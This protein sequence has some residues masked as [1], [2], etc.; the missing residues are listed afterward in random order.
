MELPF[1]RR[2]GRRDPA[3]AEENFR[4]AADINPQYTPLYFNLAKALVKSGRDDDARL[5]Y[6]IAL[7]ID[8]GCREALI[9]LGELELQ[10]GHL[11]QSRQHLLAA[12]DLQ[13]ADHD[14]HTLLARL[15]HRLDEPEL[16]EI[17]LNLTRAYPKAALPN[18]KIRASV[19]LQEA[20][21]INAL[22]QQGNALFNVG[23]FAEAESVYR[24]LVNLRNDS[25]GFHM[26][27]GKTLAEQG[28]LPEAIKELESAM[29]LDD[30]NANVVSTC[31][32]LLARA[33]QLE[34][35]REMLKKAVELDPNS[36]EAHFYSGMTLEQQ[37]ELD[38]AVEAFRRTVE[39]NP[40]NAS[41]HLYLANLLAKQGD[42]DQAMDHWRLA[43]TYQPGMIQAVAPLVQAYNKKGLYAK[44]DELLRR[45]FK[46]S[47]AN[48][49]ILT[50]LASHLAE[51]PDPQFRNRAEA[52]RV[53]EQL[54][55]IRGIDKVRSLV[56][57]ANV[58]A[59]AGQYQ[60][61]IGTLQLAQ[62]A[63]ASGRNDPAI[64]QLILSKQQEYLD[65]NTD[66]KSLQQ[67][68]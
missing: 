64:A 5:E 52:I 8:P 36:D 18:D 7:R 20:T 32:L 10:N 28:K 48:P 53:A 11:E 67:D 15:Y 22:V 4:R 19:Y 54:G 24:Q 14:V 33:G 40:A 12:A 65:R 42:L 23:R 34:R 1:R 49:V 3:N 2:V 17:E 29:A 31:G 41:G 57:L 39:L 62:Q 51:C 47:P 43:L 30:Q 60:R 21:G 46:R 58:L 25:A 37:G 6:E 61:A 63:N 9:G 13:F 56:F 27:L 38:Q 44:S 55:A 50:G 66:D 59:E 16:A 68:N 35:A 45:E 26:Q